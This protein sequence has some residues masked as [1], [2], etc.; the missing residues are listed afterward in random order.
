MLGD[1]RQTIPVLTMSQ[2]LLDYQTYSVFII[3]E[4]DKCIMEFGSAYDLTRDKF[5]GFWDIF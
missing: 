3:D 2:A 4:V 1:E 5:I